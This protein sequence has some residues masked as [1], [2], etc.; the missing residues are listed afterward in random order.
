MNH[1]FMGSRTLPPY[2]SPFK[3]ACLRRVACKVYFGETLE[4]GAGS[5]NP[6]PINRATAEVPAMATKL[7]IFLKSCMA[8]RHYNAICMRSLGPCK[9]F[10][11]QV[12][13]MSRCCSWKSSRKIVSR[14]VCLVPLLPEHCFLFLAFAQTICSSAR[15]RNLSTLNLENPR[16][17]KS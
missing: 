13:S 5:K 14:R 6:K 17:L 11:L 3:L 15:P 9:F 7:F 16:P 4:R 12:T 8:L 10:R 2:G 1:R